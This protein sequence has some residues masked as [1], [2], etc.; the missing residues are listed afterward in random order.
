MLKDVVDSLAETK[1]I[2]LGDPMDGN[3]FVLLT[4]NFAQSAVQISNSFPQPE[5]F[6]D[7]RLDELRRSS[8]LPNCRTTLLATF[9]SLVPCSLTKLADTAR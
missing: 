5:S 1:V 4:C 8:L 6:C 7:G 2:V 3:L 9:K